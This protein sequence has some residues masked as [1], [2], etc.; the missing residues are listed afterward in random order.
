MRALVFMTV[1]LAGCRAAEYTPP[2]SLPST[3]KHLAFEVV[4]RDNACHPEVLAVDRQGGGAVVTFQVTSVG[5]R[6]T[7]LIPDLGVRR[8]VPAGTRV[9]IPVLVERSGIH[10]YA[11]APGR[12]VSPFTTTGKLA[13]K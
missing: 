9:D 1:L 2:A 7:F 6:H 13:I 8:T 10:E 11:C 3:V 5:K 12:W 4:A